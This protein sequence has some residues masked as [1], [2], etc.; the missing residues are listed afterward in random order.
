MYL[1]MKLL[2]Q[3]PLAVSVA[4]LWNYSL[5]GGDK[6]IT[7]DDKLRGDPTKDLKVGN[8][9]LKSRVK[10]DDSTP[11]LDM[12]GVPSLPRLPMNRRDRQLL[13]DKQAERQNWLL[14]EPG[15]LQRKH[16]QESTL[17]V[18]NNPINRLDKEDRDDGRQDFTF[19]GVGERKSGQRQPGEIR[20]PGAASKEEAAE[21]R[22]AEQ[23]ARDDAE[24][25]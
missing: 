10:I 12:P 1:Q 23:R 11:E 18:D 22:R 17:G 13:K 25:D 7:S 8:E 3:L 16:E 19:Y 2:K 9:L 4:F 6:I 15:E 5:H 21:A 20:A 14:F 24:D